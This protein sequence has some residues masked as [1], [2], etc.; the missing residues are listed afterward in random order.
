MHLKLKLKLE[1]KRIKSMFIAATVLAMAAM[2]CSKDNNDP[3]IS[4]FTTEGTV[5]PD[6]TV[7]ISATLTDAEGL[8]SMALNI[9]TSGG[10]Q[11]KTDSKTLDG[12][13]EDYTYEF[14]IPS[15]ATDGQVYTIELSVTDD[16]KKEAL[17]TTETKTITVSIPVTAPTTTEYTV[18]ML[19]NFDNTSTGSAW[20]S[21]T[22]TVYTQAN[23]ATNSDKVDFVHY[24]GSSNA[25]TIAAPDDASLNG[26]SG[27]YDYSTNWT[28]KNATRFASTTLTYA[29][30]T[31]TD[32]DGIADPTNSKMTSL[33]VGNTFVF[34]TAGGKKGIVEV[35]QLSGSNSTSGTIT[36]KVKI[37]E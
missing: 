21:S 22:N 1:M 28:T 36:L 31:D 2:S 24:F 23:A 32:I 4:S 35:T 25:A 13:S 37:Q 8:A 18:V 5:M 6:S 7:T 9:T 3:I 14:K 34:K 17:T 26:G 27:N 15:T 30:A 12:T 16:D 10:A 20:S 19:G 11:V 29:G 33:A